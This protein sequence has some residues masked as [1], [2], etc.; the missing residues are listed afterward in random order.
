MSVGFVLLLIILSGL[1]DIGRAYFIYIA[2][3]DG[4]GE[5]ALYLSIDPA[6]K[7]AADG[8]QCADPNNAEYR[9][10]Q[11]GGDNLNWSAATITMTRPELYGV[12]D[13]VS[14]T[15]EYSVQLITPFMPRISGLNPIHLKAHATQTII[16]ET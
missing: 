7:T 14:V 8:A 5:A 12:G 16:R 11:A 10:R 15:I 2:M 1:L 13:P 6:C 4:A 3:E 9:A